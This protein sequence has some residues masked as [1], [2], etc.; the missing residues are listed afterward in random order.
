MTSSVNPV[1]AAVLLVV[2]LAYVRAIRVLHRRGVTIPRS[3]Q[4]SWHAGMVLWTTALLTPVDTLGEELL[5][6]HMAQHLLLAELG[7][8]LLLFGLRTPVLQHLLPPAILAPL[9]RAKRLRSI[10][11]NAKRPLVAIPVYALVLY[12]WHLRPAF[13]GAVEG[14]ALHALQHQSF[15]A[16]S[17]L[18]WWPAIEP[19]RRRLRGELWKIGHVLFAR[20]W[21]MF[22]GMAFIIMRSPAYPDV[23]DGARGLG[24]LDD[25]QLAG[26]MMLLLDTAIMLFAL[27]FFFWRS[28]ADHDLMERAERQAR[29][30]NASELSR[31]H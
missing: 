27:A 28:A 25:Q 3:Q 21:G 5:S 1:Q 16:I 9:A 12:G 13:E 22:L 8:P 14:G 24:V 2:W 11:R 15:I 19:E 31:L 17:V 18:V 6:A 10:G 30:D 29:S 20:I 26:G 23:Y 4:A 7:A